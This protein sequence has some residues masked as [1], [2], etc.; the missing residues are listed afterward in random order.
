MASFETIFILFLGTGG[1]ST[2]GAVC[3]FVCLSVCLS[4]LQ[5]FLKIFKKK[6]TQ[7]LPGARLAL[8]SPVQVYRSENHFGPS[9]MH[10]LMGV[11]ATPHAQS[12]NGGPRYTYTPVPPTS[13]SCLSL[14]IY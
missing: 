6:S 12:V 1:T 14:N 2:G 8:G 9:E 7:P 13:V 4:V 5:N 11:L 10:V 3:L